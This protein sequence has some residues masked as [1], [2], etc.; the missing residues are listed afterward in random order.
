M[1]AIA[2]QG[3]NI[4]LLDS[5]NNTITVYKRTSY[6]DL[7]ANALQN[8]EDQNYDAAVSYYT[9]ILQ[10]NNNYDSAYVGIGQSLYR[11]GE[12]MQAMQYFKYAY[13]T[14]NYS[15]AYSAYRKEWVEDYIILIPIIIVA[16]C[17]LISWF[18]RHAKKVN[19]RGHAYKEKRSLGEELWYAIYVIF[20]PFDGFWDIK[21]EKRG[22]VKGATTILAITVAAFLYQSV[23][24]GWLFNPYQNG[25]SYI[26]AFMAVA[27]P[28]ALWVLANWCLTTLFDGEGTFKDVY[29]ATC[30]AL[31]PLPLFVIP[32][33]IVSNFVSADEV[34]LVSMFLTL[35][36]V[37]TGFLI[38]FG[39]MTI[40]DYTLVKNIAISLF[41]LLGIAIIMF[42]AMLFTGLIQRVFTFVYNLI[43][44]IQFRM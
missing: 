24:R 25:A 42:I 39:M 37:W 32:M 8:T 11:D 23:G 38:F 29:I 16:I 14:V 9:A 36:Y 4:L 13:D 17:V 3:S 18:F 40:H 12:Y 43:V 41:T 7:I 35:A 5:T 28:V 21:H 34:S 31:T 2:Y 10:R 15:E 19:K 26:M 1:Q 44:E 20:H 22:S 6:G 30:Y 33:T 27:L